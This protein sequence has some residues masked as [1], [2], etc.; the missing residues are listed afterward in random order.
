MSHEIRTPMNGVIGM[1]ELLLDTELNARA[2]R[3]RR[4]HPRAAAEALLTVINDILDFSKIEAGKLDARADRRSTC[5]TLIEEVARLLA[6]R[7]QQKGLELACRVDPSVPDGSWATRPAPPDPD[8]PGRQRRQVHRRRARSSCRSTPVVSRG[9]PRRR[10][11]GSR[12]ATPASASP[13]TA[14]PTSSRLH[15]GRRL[16]HAPATA[17]PGWA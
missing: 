7:P 5:A 11:S 1:T 2:A 8:Q 12:S 17:A 15:P 16:D 6:P 14:R 4:D 13:R 3:L 10:L 9:R